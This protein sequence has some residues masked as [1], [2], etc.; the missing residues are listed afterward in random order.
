M[1][2]G[3]IRHTEISDTEDA[4]TSQLDIHL[5]YTPMRPTPVSKILSL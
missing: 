1:A 3:I 2:K 4:R 5:F